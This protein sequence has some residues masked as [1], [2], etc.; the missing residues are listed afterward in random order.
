MFAVICDQDR[1]PKTLARAIADSARSGNRG[2]IRFSVSAHLAEFTRL[3]V[4]N[5]R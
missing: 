5:D 4:I 1:L 2:P 3:Q